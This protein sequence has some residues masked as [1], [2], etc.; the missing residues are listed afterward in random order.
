MNRTLKRIGMFFMFIAGIAAFGAV[1]MLLWNALL[2]DIFGLPTIGFWQAAGLLV[3]A[4][5][6][7]GG[8]GHGGRKHHHG[9]HLHHHMGKN[10]FREKWMNMTPEEREKFYEQRKDF[11]GG[12]PFH[13][14]GHEGCS[15][16]KD[17][18]S[19]ATE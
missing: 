8:F 2:P 18:P 12:H 7:F 16:P 17:K 15:S 11:H 10:K 19:N 1:T 9:H 4:R 14:Y 5:I 6:F 3:L 13:H